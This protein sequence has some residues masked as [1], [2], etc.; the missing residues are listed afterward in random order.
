VTVTHYVKFVEKMSTILS[1][2]C[3]LRWVMKDIIKSGRPLSKPYYLKVNETYVCKQPKRLWSF[4]ENKRKE[5]CDYICKSFHELYVH[6]DEAHASNGEHVVDLCVLCGNIY[7]PG[8]E[9]VCS[10]VR[11]QRLLR[12]DLNGGW[13]A[14]P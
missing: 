10:R 13:V 11:T 5:V 14:E 1:P 2:A 4:D 8:D 6:F 7:E 3:R 12:E 9:D